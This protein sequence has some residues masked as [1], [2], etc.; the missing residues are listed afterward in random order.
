M[1][2][3]KPPIA[4]FAIFASGF[5][6]TYSALAEVVT[7][8]CGDG[9]TTVLGVNLAPKS[10]PTGFP[11]DARQ[12]FQDRL[13]NESLANEGLNAFFTEGPISSSPTSFDLFLDDA[14]KPPKAHLIGNEGT[15][16]Y[17]SNFGCEEN[18]SCNGRFNTTPNDPEGP[19]WETKQDFSVKFN[20]AVSAFGFYATDIG[21]F[22]AGLSLNLFD[23]DN[24]LIKKILVFQNPKA[25]DVTPE[26]SA[27]MDIDSPVNALTDVL[28]NGNLLFFGFT[29]TSGLIRSISFEVTP[30]TG[31]DDYFGFDDFVTGKFVAIEPPGIP[32]PATLALV[33]ASL[34]ALAATRRRRPR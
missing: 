34:G 26:T 10:E 5:F 19:W 33:A 17:L 20:E 8:T 14:G 2:R 4:S 29:D 6:A 24:N 25:P 15:G 7:G 31:V 3:W 12:A 27:S 21:D 1:H 22:E 9:C 18:G 16:N 13:V 11:V 23:Q 28:P 30:G 32:E